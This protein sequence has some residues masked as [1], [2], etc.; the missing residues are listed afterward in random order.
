MFTCQK[1]TFSDKS[2]YMYVHLDVD[3]KQMSCTVELCLGPSIF[4]RLVPV[5]RRRTWHRAMST[6]LFQPAFK[7][8]NQTVAGPVDQGCFTAH[9]SVSEF[10]IIT[11][12]CTQRRVVRSFTG[13]NSPS[14]RPSVC[15]S[16]NSC[17]HT[18]LNL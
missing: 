7:A 16:D 14:V 8:R 17:Y 13:S 9:V 10:R 3:F 5:G 2:T 4:W 1:I 11:S 18:R 12:P 6:K 15:L